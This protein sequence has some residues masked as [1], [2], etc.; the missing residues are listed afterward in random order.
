[1]DV[2]CCKQMRRARANKKRGKVSKIEQ[3][4]FCITFH[5]F[6]FEILFL[7]KGTKAVEQKSPPCHILIGSFGTNAL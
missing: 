3:P 2:E 7:F 6:V 4:Q 1:M 5:F